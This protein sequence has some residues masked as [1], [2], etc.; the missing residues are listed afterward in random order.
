M[1]KD[2]FGFCF[3]KLTLIRDFKNTDNIILIFFVFFPFF[4]IKINWEPNMLYMFFLFS[5]FFKIK[6]NFQKG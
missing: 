6:N 2:I 4:R 1:V 3:L 5:L